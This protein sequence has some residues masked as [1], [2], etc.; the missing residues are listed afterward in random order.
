MSAGVVF[1]QMLI[2]FSLML[3]GLFFRK[4]GLVSEQSA[5]D[6][7]VIVVNLCS[8]MQLIMSV[9]GTDH[10]PSE[11][12]GIIR[13]FLFSMATYIVIILFGELLRLILRIPAKIQG[14]YQL[15]NVFGN[16]GFIGIPV[17][18]ALF[19]ADSLIYVAVFNL[20]W[21]LFFY[22]YGLWIITRD[23]EETH[24][25]LTAQLKQMINPG[26]ISC[27][28]TILLFWFRIEVPSQLQDL[29]SYTGNAATF[30]ALFVIGASLC[31][32]KWSDII[33]DYRMFLFTALRFAVFPVT[34]TVMIQGLVPDSII[35]GTLA[36]MV[37]VP[38]GNMPA[39]M[40]AQFGQDNRLTAKGAVVTTMLSILTITLTCMFV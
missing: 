31:D 37:A 24:L 27:V 6:L 18:Q 3:M 8:P 11:N 2:I 1:S 22:T 7:S 10:A 16:C 4:R 28:I 30:L 35:R 32:L 19:G 12:A 15:M 5:K 9:F 29:C 38:V 14:D 25:S 21:C 26:T 40:R 23:G 17:A 36:L 13:F 33:K 34:F 20:C 39:M